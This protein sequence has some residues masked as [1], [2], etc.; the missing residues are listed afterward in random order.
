MVAA[1]PVA[2]G[3]A[4]IR[5]G[6]TATSDWALIA[7]RSLETLSWDPPLTGMPTS[8]SLYSDGALFHPGPLPFWIFATPTRLLGE[9]GYGLIVGAVACNVAAI[10]A[11]FVLFRRPRV[12]ELVL[13]GAVLVALLE[14]TAGAVLLRDPFNPSIAVLPMF[15][16][17][18][19]TWSVLAGHPK[20]MIVVVA[21]GSIA[22]QAH[23]M[24]LPTFALLL[25]VASAS[26]LTSAIQHG[27]TGARRAARRWGAISAGLLVLCWSGPL[28]DQVAGDGN[29][30]GLLTSGS[31]VDGS[32]LRY[33]TERMLA[34][35][36][37]SPWARFSGRQPDPHLMPVEVALGV[38]MLLVVAATGVWAVRTGRRSLAAWQMMALL[39][40]AGAVLTTARVPVS[41]FGGTSS[42][43]SAL[44]WIPVGAVLR[45][46][47]VW[48][49]A[50]A[51]SS[52]AL[53]RRPTDRGGGGQLTLSA[54]AAAA[55]VAAMLSLG[56][57]RPDGD[58][59]SITWGAARV[60]AAAIAREVPPGRTVVLDADGSP[61]STALIPTLLGQ[62]RLHDVEVLYTK[63]LPETGMF[64]QYHETGRE[65]ATDLMIVLIRAGDE[66]DQPLAD[67]RLI[68]S[69]DPSRPIQRYEGYDRR[70]A[71][72][73]GSEPTAVHVLEGA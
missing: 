36:T 15:A 43:A 44:I 20:A 41:S 2:A 52:L 47:V 34:M 70:S 45:F 48:G 35:I 67:H 61:G 6:W 54:A 71:F 11:T 32:G 42:P 73:S 5:G 50:A 72:G 37:K 58:P 27:R 23:V 17:C 29:L 51:V 22:A 59:G 1:A 26:L 4:A 46:A 7:A 55:V 56:P 19:A 49:L 12:P 24:N 39:A 68:S 21:F 31:S 25:V 9:P 28:V 14:V 62:L 69:Y 63:R 40:S 64:P 3:L 57:L 8:L 53:R 18:I 10:A 65:R 38:A 33:G 13:G 16:L 66:A 60:H 30:M